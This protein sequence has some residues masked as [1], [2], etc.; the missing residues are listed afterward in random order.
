[1]ADRK[2]SQLITIGDIDVN[3]DFIPILDDSEEAGR[4]NKK[5]SVS[6]LGQRILETNTTE[7]LEEGG[8][9]LYY[10]DSRVYSKTKSILQPGGNVDINFDDGEQTITITFP[11]AVTVRHD[12]NEFDY[13]GK[14]VVGSSE[15][16]NVWTIVR[17]T[18]ASDGT[19][20]KSTATN[21]NWTDRYTHNYI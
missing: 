9:N 1:M 16:S 20:T 17:L 4:K 19:T 12:F 2:V 18:I 6:A 14:A 15:D 11:N 8:E 5:V 7:M 13:L 21:V 3:L 10:T